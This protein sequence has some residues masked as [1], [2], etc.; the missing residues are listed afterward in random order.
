MKRELAY[1]AQSLR[2]RATVKLA[3][4]SVPEILPTAIYGV[5]VAK[6]TDS[7]LAG[8][9][10]Q[11]IGWLGGLIAA[12][13]LG[14]VGARQVYGRLGDLVEPVRDDLVR[15]VVGGA[16]RSGDESAVARLNRQV[17]IVRDTFAGLVMVI[18]SFGVTLF[19]VL[20]GLLSLA[21]LV[22]AFVV[23]PFLLGFALSLAVLGMAADRVRASLQ[24][25]EELA[26]SAGMVFGGVRDLTATGAEEY[27]ERLVGEPIEAH[28]SAERALA[29][30]GALRTLC[31][32]VGGWL[33]LL[34]LLAAGPWLIGRGVSTGTLLGGLTYV[35]IG[36]QPALGTVMGA[37]GDS[38]LRFVITL[39][40]ILDVTQQTEPERPLDT[41]HGHRVETRG[42]T[43][44]YGPKAEPV[45]DHLDLSIPEGDH[46]AVVGPSGIG[47]STLAALICGMLTPTSG[48]LSLGGVA[49]T[50]L[51]TAALAETRVLIPQEAYVFS[52]TVLEN[53]IY[54]LPDA[55]TT[56]VSAAIEAIGAGALITRIGGLEAT[57]KPADL[58]AGE[59]QLLALVRAY[60]SPAPLVVLD[61]ATCFLDAEAERQAEEA[62][63]HRGGT[64]IVIAHR[65]TSALRA[66]RIL[67]LDGT[68]ATLGTHPTLLKTSPLYQDLHGN[69]TPTPPAPTAA[70][71]QPPAGTP[72]TAPPADHTPPAPTA[73]EDTSTASRHHLAAGG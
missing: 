66:R 28:A 73:T 21:P 4:W 54:L 62:F 60:L 61:E 27:A 35:L 16:L 68:Q 52:G 17:E 47:K 40:R 41:A 15:R 57:V 11:G 53:L 50:E 71:P 26:A 9:V 72:P 6:A 63:A 43:F 55:T 58:S 65:I 18:R 37:L 29:K 31:F 30:V 22:A 69:W 2:S 36:L 51:S 70:H 32:A 7:F 20:A 14:A 67:V 34:I 49:P 24:A 64:L 3:A 12:A 33:P 25:D 5:A 10:W 19:G 39:G 45:L 13:G 42:L 59:R 46:L 44:A 23:P 56:E 8:Q 1:G 38:G 48:Q